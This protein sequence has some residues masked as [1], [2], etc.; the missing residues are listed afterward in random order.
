MPH[1]KQ[2]QN[3]KKAS[4]KGRRKARN[5]VIEQQR[6]NTFKQDVFSVQCDSDILVLKR[7]SLKGYFLNT[8]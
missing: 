8:L 3:N 1:N 5:K 6:S 2:Q 4:E 7:D